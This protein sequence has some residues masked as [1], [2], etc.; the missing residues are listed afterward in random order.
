MTNEL[1]S[2][3]NERRAGI[4]DSPIP[5]KSLGELIRATKSAIPNKQKAR[6]VF[7]EMLASGATVPQAIDKLG[8]KPAMGEDQ[9]RP[10]VQKAIAA[11]AKAVAD[12][13]NGKTKAADAIKG[14]VMRETK[15]SARMEVVQQLLLAEL[16][17][18]EA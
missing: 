15:G 16:E 18:A 2:T 11:N 13:K 14:A 7:A 9:L 3:L 17:K 4:A 6:E 1:L 5:A 8:I 12:F 10:I